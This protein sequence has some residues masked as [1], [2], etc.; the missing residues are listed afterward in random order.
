MMRTGEHRQRVSSGVDKTMRPHAVQVR[1]SRCQSSVQTASAEADQA[2]TMRASGGA[3]QDGRGERERPAK[4]GLEVRR[5][6]LTPFGERS[7]T[8]LHVGYGRLRKFP[9]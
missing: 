6:D 7:S 3:M 2:P 8:L 4:I 5:G 1:N 9:D